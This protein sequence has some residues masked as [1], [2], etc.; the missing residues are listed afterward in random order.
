M[1]LSNQ[2]IYIIQREMK[3]LITALFVYESGLELRQQIAY[4]IRVE[5]FLIKK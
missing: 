2:I 1:L 5:I 3:I 4:S